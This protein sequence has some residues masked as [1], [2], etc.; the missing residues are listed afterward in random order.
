MD[1]FSGS[2]L[3]KLGF[4]DYIWEDTIFGDWGCTTYKLKEF[5]IRKD[6]DKLSKSDVDGEL[7]N[8]CA[9]AGLVGVF[10]LEEILKFN[11]DFKYP[12]NEYGCEW[13]TVIED[14][15][16]EIEYIVDG[17]NEAHIKGIGNVNFITVQTSL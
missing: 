17:N 2:G 16:G 15:D 4:T 5:A 9:D 1:I 14:F 12:I 7:G 6:V 10:Y 3:Q 11:P 8:F 13:A